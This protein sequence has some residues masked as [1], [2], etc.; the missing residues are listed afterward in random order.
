MTEQLEIERRKCNLIIHRVEEID[1]KTDAEQVCDIL[2]R[3]LHFDN[4]DRHVIDV[5][6]VGGPVR[7]RVR[8]VCVKLQTVEGK[9]E[10]LRQAKYLKGKI[11]LRFL[12]SRTQQQSNTK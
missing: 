10:V 12:F 8:P 7:D 9:Y 1:D 2:K 11:L 4:D 3:G 5:Q 6:R